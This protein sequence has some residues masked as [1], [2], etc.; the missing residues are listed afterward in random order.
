MTLSLSDQRNKIASKVQE[1]FPHFKEKRVIEA[2]LALEKLQKHGVNSLTLEEKNSLSTKTLFNY[3]S[4]IQFEERSNPDNPELME[5][6]A[7]GVAIYPTTSKNH[8]IYSKEELIKAAK[9]LK[10]R[11]FQR[12]HSF[13]AEDTIGTVR[14][15]KA[16]PETGVT[17]YEAGLDPED[18]VTRKIE[19]GHI[20][21]VSVLGSSTATCTACDEEYTWYHEHE[22][23]KKYDGK[24]AR[25]NHTN[26]RYLHLGATNYPG[27]PNASVSAES[28]VKESYID[29]NGGMFLST[30]DAYSILR[31]DMTKLFT[32]NTTSIFEL[33]NENNGD[34]NMPDEDTKFKEMAKQME[35]LMA[36][37][38]KKDDDLE[39]FKAESESLEKTIREEKVNKIVEVELYLKVLEKEKVD[40][41]KIT[42]SEW[43]KDKLE[44]KLETLSEWKDHDIKSR[45]L[46]NPPSNE[47]KSR[48]FDQNNNN[49]GKPIELTK[50][51]IF[52]AEVEY[53]L[54]IFWGQGFVSKEAVRSNE[55]YDKDKKQWKTPSSIIL[56]TATK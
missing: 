17:T 11:P 41:R 6:I 40:L 27:I 21:N 31:E 35:L 3:Y 46:T 8:S 9:T 44:S 33:D 42:L 24:I 15:V 28:V 54:E 16:D 48:V 2:T 34:K 43:N 25:V 56:R 10:N 30:V 4:P 47:G 1:F 5:K 45:G 36:E 32:E 26:I 53:L 39:K 13:A 49:S 7:K 14:K 55:L 23:G 51:V 37:N 19:A 50:E 18:P 22:L 38:K 52:E 20:K 29:K 12:N